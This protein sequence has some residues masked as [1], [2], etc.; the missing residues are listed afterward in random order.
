MSAKTLMI[1]DRSPAGLVGLHKSKD[2]MRLRLLSKAESWQRRA[3]P[4]LGQLNFSG[5][6]RT[7]HGRGKV[8]LTGR[9]GTYTT[10]GAVPGSFL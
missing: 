1:R 9:E 10:F 4:P 8:A 3:V 5:V 7:L 6:L 2:G